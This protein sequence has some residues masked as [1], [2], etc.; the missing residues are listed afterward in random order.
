MLWH[1]YSSPMDSDNSSM[2]EVNNFLKLI[3]TEKCS[4][5]IIFLQ[6]FYEFSFQNRKISA[7]MGMNLINS[8]IL[9]VIIFKI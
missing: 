4:K 2:F 3:D 8:C 5:F 6:T 9:E 7:L 1:T